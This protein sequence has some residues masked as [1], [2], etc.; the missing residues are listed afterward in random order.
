MSILITGG[1]GFIGS[2]LALNM[3][4]SKCGGIDVVDYSE[5][6]CRYLSS[7]MEGEGGCDRVNV[8]CDDYS[9][10]NSLQ[11]VKDGMYD[12]I[13]HLAAVP[14]VSYS[15]EHPSETTYEN[16]YKFSSLL[17]AS[18]NSCNRVIFASSSSVYGGNENMPTSEKEPLSPQSPYALQKK[19][20]EEMCSLFSDLYNLDT[21]CFRFF[22]VFGPHQFGDSPY[23]TVI[24]AWCHALSNNSKL[25]LDGTGEVS[26]DFCYIDNV[27][28]I[29]MKCMDSSKRYDAEPFNVACGDR[30]S[31]TEILEYIM[32]EYNICDNNIDHTP[33]RPGDVMHTCAD[34]SKT[35]KEFSI[36][37][38]RQVSFWDGLKRTEEWWKTIG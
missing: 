29:I 14:R 3:A 17:E 36:D 22:N 9:S 1:A 34:M 19:V 6:N 38:Q 8:I 32:R 15:V 28:D 5:D 18:I 31:L 21:V 27:C 35:Y 26:R 7:V 23:S 12:Q 2:N 11:R 20:G 33:P 25:R 16:I 13:V 24:S 37:P 30:N 10:K 4:R